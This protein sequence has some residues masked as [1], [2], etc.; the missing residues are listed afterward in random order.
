MPKTGRFKFGSESTD[1]VY[2]R[3]EIISDNDLTGSMNRVQAHLKKEAEIRKVVPL[4]RSGL[5]WIKKFFHKTCTKGHF[6]GWGAL[7]SF[8]TGLWLGTEN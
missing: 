1:S 5:T 6:R 4:K 7:D 8:C 2:R 3:H